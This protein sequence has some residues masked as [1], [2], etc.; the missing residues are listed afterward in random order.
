MSKLLWSGIGCLLD[1]V[2]SFLVLQR[3]NRHAA[4]SSHC[5]VL[6]KPSQFYDISMFV[7][8]GKHAWLQIFFQPVFHI[9]PQP[10]RELKVRAMFRCTLSTPWLPTSKLCPWRVQLAPARF[11]NASPAAGANVKS[12]ITCWSCWVLLLQNCVWI[13]ILFPFLFRFYVCVC[14][15]RYVSCEY[16]E[17]IGWFSVINKQGASA[18]RHDT[19]QRS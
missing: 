4:W 14:E 18:W 6:S 5:Q 17:P 13:S 16:E 1:G 19:G 8:S 12:K 9:F 7:P 15:S 3:A 2:G 11:P 10:H